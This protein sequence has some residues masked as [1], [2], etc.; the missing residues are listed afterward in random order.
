MCFLF[1]SISNPAKY[2]FYE[3]QPEP[4]GRQAPVEKWFRLA[5][6]VFIFLPSSPPRSADIEKGVKSPSKSGGK[7]LK[8]VTGKKMSA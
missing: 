6:L 1:I 5:Q 4:V 7:I 3:N 8:K 2:R